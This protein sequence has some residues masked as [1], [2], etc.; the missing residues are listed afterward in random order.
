MQYIVSREDKLAAETF[1]NPP[2]ELRAAPFWA[3]NN[4]LKADIL[5]RQMDNFKKMGFG[6][7]F[8]HVRPGYPDKYFTDEYIDSICFCIKHSRENGMLAYLYDED[9]WPSGYAGGLITK[10]RKDK[11]KYMLLSKTEVPGLTK[12]SVFDVELDSDGYLVSYSRVENAD[13]AVHTV[14]YFGEGI[15][16]D[17]SWFGGSTYADTLS[18]S[19]MN[20][21]IDAT[22]EKYSELFG[23]EF[24]HTVRS[25]FTDEPQFEKADKPLENPFSDTAKTPW[26]DDFEGTFEKEY[27][28]DLT[29]RL[30]E[31]YFTLKNKPSRVKYDYY[32]H[33][34][35]RFSKA[36]CE[37]VGAWCEK[38]NLILTGHFMCE[39]PLENQAHANAEAMY[40]YK[41]FQMPGID[42]LLD[43]HEFVTAKQA[44]SVKNQYGR[45]GMTCE[46]Y[47]VTGWQMDFKGFLHQGNWLA[48]LGVTMR[49]PHLSWMSMESSA[50]RDFPSSINSQAP[51]HTEYKYI[52]DHFARVNSLLTR[53]VPDNKIAVLH[54]IESNWL[55]CGDKR[56]NADEVRHING[57][58]DDI[59]RYLLSAMLDFEYISE[60][61]LPEQCVKASY[62]LALGKSGYEVV[63]VPPM[64]TIRKSTLDILR[65]FKEKGGEIIVYGHAPRYV[66]AC[67]NPSE[68]SFFDEIKTLYPERKELVSSLAKYRKYGVYDENGAL[69]P[70]YLY[71]ERIDGED[72]R[73]F[74]APLN[75]PAD[76][77]CFSKRDVTV[78]IK[79]EYFP[80]L[81]DTFTGEIN[82]VE[83][84]HR[85]GNTYIKRSMYQFDTLLLSLSKNPSAAGIIQTGDD[86][87]IQDKVH[88][89]G[90]H[91]VTLSE[92]NVMLLDMPEYSF[93][94]INY[95]E[96]EEILRLNGTVYGALSKHPEYGNAVYLKYTFDSEIEY[97][98]PFLALEGLAGASVSFN[99]MNADM[100]QTGYY[101]DE[102][103]T[104][105]SLP[106][107]K[108][109]TNVL[110][111]K[112][113][114]SKVRSLE[115]MYLLGKFGVSTEGDIS[116]VIPFDGTLAFGNITCQGLP[117]YGANI[118]YHLKVKAKK[119]DI[120]CTHI[121]GALA[122]VD[123]D[124]KRQGV[125]CV[126]PYKCS[127]DCENEGIHDVDITY[128]GNR[129]NTLM[130]LH[131]ADLSLYWIGGNAWAQQNE[132]F[133]YEYMLRDS[134]ILVSPE[135]QIIL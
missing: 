2:A 33:L 25:I 87:I 95:T 107:I 36:F 47:G 58:F 119:F 108:K 128:F 19:T 96:R 41:A 112:Y 50:K 82:P 117:F 81:Y 113:D 133:C 116:R 100:T 88:F 77:E 59:T 92:D 42:I 60:S 63:V 123:V 5:E 130:P 39:H 118:T 49:V 94:G 13:S 76:A 45:E 30:P 8:M 12:N 7:Y 102:A 65:A 89:S 69:M 85:D 24:S 86:A 71:N 84:E 54:P 125:I 124:G 120:Q 66:D 103:E 20:K 6:G 135:I 32:K 14:Y 115:A 48:G 93:D 104:K 122:S 78:Y 106:D 99:G 27:G 53:G 31:L 90:K 72:I 134:G 9:K 129:Y 17:S 68:L 109:G 3:W 74:I 127:V 131:N 40:C 55:L 16:E 105:I 75:K 126:P 61:L 98:A 29:E 132:K 64:L 51:W 22:H 121:A 28:Y 73:L 83:C 35:Y 80:T 97:S 15:F 46:C 26:S 23:D 37:N 91:P 1:K 10:D 11:Q 43:W 4:K 18:E 21:F 114:M 52:E 62:P 79:G 70:E 34:L 56:N 110:V 101:I 111:V 67:E 44:Q 57:A 38:H